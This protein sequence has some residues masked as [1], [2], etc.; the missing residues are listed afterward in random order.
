MKKTLAGLLVFVLLVLRSSGLVVAAD[1]LNNPYGYNFTQ[2]EFDEYQAATQNCD[3]PSL[4]CLV[5]YTTRFVA[6]EW[7]CDIAGT[8]PA[9]VTSSG[10]EPDSDASSQQ[11]PRGVVAGVF[12]LLGGMYD[13]QP[14]KTSRYVADVVDSAGFA[15]PAYAQGLGFASLDPILGLWK[16]F[17]NVAYFF[18]ILVFIIIGF[19]IMFRAKIGGQ[20]VITAQQAI[21]SVI[22]SLVLVTF[23][24]AIAGF[25]IDLMYLLMFMIIGLF[26]G[27]SNTT[28]DT[29][30]KI[31][32]SS[33][34]IN[35]DI[36]H[37]IGFMFSN[38][39]S[40]FGTGE[41]ISRQFLNAAGITNEFFN[42]L[43]SWL[44]GLT[45]TIII[46]IGALIATVKLFFE[47]LKSYATIILSVVFSPLA[48]MIG[49]FPGKNVF[50]PWLKG[51]IGNLLAFPTVLLLVIMFIEFTKGT[52]SH[53]TEGGFM[54]PFLIG[55][56]VA[57][58]VG[59]LMGFAII[60]A[61]PEIVK[62]V[63]EAT[64]A[65]D[66]GFAAMIAG[67]AWGRAKEAWKGSPYSLG[68]GAKG[69]I[70]AP[71]DAAMATGGGIMGYR[72]AAAKAKEL[73]LEGKKAQFAKAGG[74]LAGILAGP[75]ALNLAPQGIKTLATQYAQNQA[76]KFFTDTDEAAKKKEAEARAE[77]QRQA[78][79]QTQ[80]QQKK[81][82]DQ[83]KLNNAETRAKESKF[84]LKRGG[85]QTS[86]L[87]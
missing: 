31:L 45:L 76:Q 44:G 43:G 52:A 5:K 78:A 54:P 37:L 62:K 14:A 26:N 85:S 33:D 47:L 40:Q 3:T 42:G 49:A 70:K 35:L 79:E 10:N 51:I 8:C 13:Y 63:K 22:I 87:E 39:V 36:M 56:S 19:M 27:I 82:L 81:V 23:S 57:G 12:T 66:G 59:P 29:A 46:T 24:Y 75:R 74:A 41:L 60:L 32:N 20:A 1:D 17:R 65:S 7:V 84:G 67:A 50:S 68:I 2:T 34:L 53:T 4:E 16:L 72:Y 18:F 21:P 28:P 38:T 64:G 15:T 6:M 48:L 77:Q 58:M 73:G 69:I 9:K 11:Q 61:M 86:G 25:M 80:A 30:T 83:H 71:V 55:S